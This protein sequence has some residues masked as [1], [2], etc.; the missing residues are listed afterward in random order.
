MLSVGICLFVC[1]LFFV[2]LFVCLFVFYH[3]AR[4]SSENYSET[5][6]YLK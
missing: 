5:D 2:C 3:G 4:F 6:I 1:C